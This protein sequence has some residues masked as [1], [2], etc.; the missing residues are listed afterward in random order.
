MNNDIYVD[1]QGLVLEFGLSTANY[2]SSNDMVYLFVNNVE[3][4]Q[5]DAGG[6]SFQHSLDPYLHTWISIRASFFTTI[7]TAP[8]ML[9]A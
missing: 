4:G 5:E 3:V 8:P 1:S 2:S 7:V 6:S 9:A